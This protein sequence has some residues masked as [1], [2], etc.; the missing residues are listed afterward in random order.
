MNMDDI[1]KLMD[2]AGPVDIL[3]VD[4]LPAA[5]EVVAG[6]LY[7]LLDGNGG[8]EK[9]YHVGDGW[10][11]IGSDKDPQGEPVYTKAEIDAMFETVDIKNP[12]S[13]CPNCGAK[14]EPYKGEK[15]EIVW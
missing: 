5:E 4:K 13:N 10:V 15:N 3:C 2:E 14:M 12:P 9:Y 11:S 6:R 8:Y 7:V 1:K